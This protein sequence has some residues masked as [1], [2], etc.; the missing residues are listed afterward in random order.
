MS[1]S[2]WANRFVDGRVALSA[3]LAASLLNACI[4]GID[5]SETVPKS[6]FL[7]EPLLIVPY[8]VHR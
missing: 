7:C 5:G 6:C 2:R 8:K 1:Y 3:L 4:L